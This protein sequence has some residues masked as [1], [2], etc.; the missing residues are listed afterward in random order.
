MIPLKRCISA[1]LKKPCKILVRTEAEQIVFFCKVMEV[2]NEL[3]KRIEER[4]I[5]NGD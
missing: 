1:E 2:H 4:M 3:L 5:E